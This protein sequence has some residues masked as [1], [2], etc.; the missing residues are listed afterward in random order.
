VRATPSSVLLLV[1]HTGT[2][3]PAGAVP[4]DPRELLVA[5]LQVLQRGDVVLELLHTAGS[6]QG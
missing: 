2:A 3:T 6:D 5:E 1:T 4:V